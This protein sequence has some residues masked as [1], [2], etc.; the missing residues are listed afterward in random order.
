MKTLCLLPR[1]YIK[2]VIFNQL[3]VQYVFYDHEFKD[4]QKCVN[5]Q[6]FVFRNYIETA[7]TFKDTASTVLSETKQ[8]MHLMSSW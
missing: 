6:R 7:S 2:L 4:F 1:Q 5:N 3:L 8:R